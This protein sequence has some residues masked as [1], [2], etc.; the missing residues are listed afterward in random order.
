MLLFSL[1]LV[2]VFLGHGVTRTLAD[3]PS[4]IPAIEAHHPINLPWMDNDVQH[5]HSKS[6]LVCRS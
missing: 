6:F 1:L 5:S 2:V 3:R 4:Y